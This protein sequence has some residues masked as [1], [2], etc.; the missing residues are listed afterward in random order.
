MEGTK[1]W[2][3][4]L[5]LCFP[6]EK[7]FS[8]GIILHWNCF[9][10]DQRGPSYALCRQLLS[11]TKNLKLHY[12]GVEAFFFTKPCQCSHCE[13]EFSSQGKLGASAYLF[14]FKFLVNF[15]RPQTRPQTP[16]CR[17]FENMMDNFLLT[18]LPFV[19]NFMNGSL[20]HY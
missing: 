5:Q 6:L 19:S 8:R 12:R 16:S 2:K 15:Q 3:I 17:I 1:Q 7:F 4:K 13:H 18:L 10:S 9:P 14:L 20:M 11:W